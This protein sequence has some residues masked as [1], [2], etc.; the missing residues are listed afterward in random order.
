MAKIMCVRAWKPMRENTANGCSTILRKMQNGSALNSHPYNHLLYVFLRSAR[1]LLPL[2]DSPV[3]VRGI[4]H[5]RG[6]QAFDSGSKLHALH[7]LREVWKPRQ[8]RSQDVGKP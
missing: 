4:S 1:S 3:G 7:T 8:F 2:L 5:R 6:S